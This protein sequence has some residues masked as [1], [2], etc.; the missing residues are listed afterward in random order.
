L[1]IENDSTT[2]STFSSIKLRS[3]TFDAGIAAINDGTTNGG[4]LVLL[5][6]DTTGG[7]VVEALTILDDSGY[8]GIG[9]TTPT[10]PLTIEG[11]VSASGYLQTTGIYEKSTYP[12]TKYI[13]NGADAGDVYLQAGSTGVTW[14]KISLGGASHADVGIKLFTAGTERFT[15]DYAGNSH[16]TGSLGVSSTIYS[17][18]PDSGGSIT[19]NG[20]SGD[21]NIAFH[22]S[23]NPGEGADI[24]YDSSAED[25]Y[26]GTRYSTGTFIAFKTGYGDNDIVTNGTEHL[27]IRQDGNIG[28]GTTAPDRLLHLYSGV[29]GAYIDDV[30]QFI[31]EDEDARIQLQSSNAGSQ[32]S[33]LILS[34]AISS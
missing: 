8:V 17:G 27:R 33:A 1:T 2:T 15:I 9:T 24:H 3:N 29:A 32:G 19:I 10:W 20:S 4:R 12:Y 6:D 31:I 16:I 5:V 34:N 28:I 30:A 23:S 22:H 18:N 7:A 21:P 25:L 14:T 13:K 26:I 11:N